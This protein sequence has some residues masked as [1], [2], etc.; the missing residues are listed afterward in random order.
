M[1]HPLGSLAVFAAGNATVNGVIIAHRWLQIKSQIHLERNSRMKHQS[2]STSATAQP[3][4]EL[5]DPNLIACEIKN[6]GSETF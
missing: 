5:A 4:Y 3:S 1:F 2:F 6:T